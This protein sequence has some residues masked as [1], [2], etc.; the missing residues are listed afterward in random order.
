MKLRQSAKLISFTI[1]ILS[2][3]DS[4]HMKATGANDS[5]IIPLDLTTQRPVVEL[6]ING[7]GPFRFIFDTG[8]SGSV[9]DANLAT[10]AGLKVIGE[11]SLRTPG[12]DNVI[13]SKRV[14][15][16]MI[17]FAGTDISKDATMNTMDLREMLPVDG[18][19]SPDF[20]ANYLITLDYPGSKLILESGELDKTAKDVTPFT[21]KSGVISLDAFIA[22]NK[23]EAHLDSG[24]PGGFDIPFSLK[25][26]LDFKKGPN[27]AGVINT[28]AASFK[29]WQAI[30]IGDIRVGSVT[31][32]NPEVHLVEG[33]QFVNFGYQILKDLK[34]TI[35]GKNHLIKFEKSTSVID[36][37]KGQEEGQGEKNDFTG[38]YG[39]HERKVFLENGVMYLQ[40]R[41]APRLKLLKIK[42]DEYEMVFNMPVANELPNVR[43]ER[44]ESRMVIGLTFVFKDGRED[45]VTKDK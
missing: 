13:M 2:G 44:D 24:N 14:K 40:R 41:S 16:L 3:L 23:L 19:L 15:A 30:L 12:S 4:C 29:K 21:Q 8:A 9:I 33:F 38:W 18:I 25:D 43:F 1:I 31:Y 7:K 28:S 37:K 27:E 42:D 35:D 39:E 32:K 45:F 11:D 6:Q 34:T 17:T 22:E 10:E 26:Q 20:F 36:G 5:V